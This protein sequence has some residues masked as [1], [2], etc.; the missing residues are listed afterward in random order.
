MSGLAN[1]AT[2]MSGLVQSEKQPAI[3]TYEQRMKELKARVMKDCLTLYPGRRPGWECGIGWTDALAKLSYK[4]ECANQLFSRNFRVHAEADQIKEKFGRLR[5]YYTVHRDAP[6]IIERL[7]WF[8]RKFADVILHKADFRTKRVTIKP[9]TV[10][11]ECKELPPP[12][13]PDDPLY[14][15]KLLESPDGFMCQLNKVYQYEVSKH[16]PTRLQALWHIA[17]ACYKVE[18]WLLGLYSANLNRQAIGAEALEDFVEKAIRETE[19]ACHST[20]E[21][22]GSS[23]GTDYLPR[24]ETLGWITYICERCAKKRGVKYRKGNGIYRNGELI[25]AVKKPEYDECDEEGYQT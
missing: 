23:I 5:F 16:V 9:A 24:C 21:E 11:I 1:A 17:Y 15:G 14:D 20:C 22:C 4:I 10:T 6:L 7:S 12:S 3:N 25:K 19:D 13:S 8:L 2:P 18:S